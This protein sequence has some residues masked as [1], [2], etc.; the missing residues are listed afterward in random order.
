MS[1]YDHADARDHAIAATADVTAD[2]QK[3][4]RRI[5]L[6]ERQRSSTR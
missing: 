5:S 1:R 4:A 3:K 6:E 2:G